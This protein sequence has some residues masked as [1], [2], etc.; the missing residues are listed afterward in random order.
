M[1]ISEAIA[2]LAAG[3]SL[4][5]EQ[6]AQCMSQIMSG[7]ATDAQIA[8]FLIALKVKGETVE[9]IAGAA[10]V[11][12]EKAT[13]IASRHEVIVDTCG[14][15]GDRSGT[16]NIS[17][18]AAFV[19]SGAELPVAKHG[20][21]SITS[22]CGSADLLAG[23]GVNIDLPPE[24]VTQCLDEVGIGFLFAPMLHTAMKY[25][26]GVRR[27]L[28]P[29][30]TVFNI[31]GPLTNPAGANRQVIGVFR[32]DIVHPIAE[33]LKLLGAERAF[34]VHG[35]DH[36]D[37]I[38]TTGPTTVSELREGSISDYTI[39]PKQFDMPRA[40]V[41][42]LKGGDVER[43]VAITHGVLDG[44]T[45][46]QRDIV[47]INAAAALVAGGAA[48]DLAGGIELARESIDSG[49]AREKL[50]RLVAATNA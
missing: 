11:M 30:P 3:K 32:E 25:A 5:R 28:A 45:G 26:I 36:L 33:V 6:T 22:K 39:A 14:T 48:D 10:D 41:D 27:E 44:H 17:T 38:T 9:E 2:Q 13:R 12:R 15:G 46:P 40:S 1:N 20:N 49:K 37:E 31:L 7:E 8:G 16:F 43:N 23:L 24:R 47:L 35:S 29:T 19:V 34:V 18:T 50:T 4:S 42:D 21:R